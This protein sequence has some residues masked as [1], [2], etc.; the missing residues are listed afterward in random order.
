MDISSYSSCAIRLENALE[1]GNAISVDTTVEKLPMNGETI[2]DMVM[3]H[4]N[5]R[6]FFLGKL[7]SRL[8][9]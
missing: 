2:T 9:L 8:C 3:L 6:R 4:N 1:T 5:G 7:Q